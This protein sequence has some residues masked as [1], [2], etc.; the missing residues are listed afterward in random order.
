MRQQ[1][2]FHF[3]R[4]IESVRRAKLGK[5]L[6]SHRS[7]H[8]KGSTNLEQGLREILGDFV[9]ASVLTYIVN[10]ISEAFRI[11]CDGCTNLG[12]I[13]DHVRKN[14]QLRDKAGMYS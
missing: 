4:V 12:K 6:S 2:P 1:G 3:R 10:N 11:N 8:G 13:I 14:H 9:A 7:Q 5:G